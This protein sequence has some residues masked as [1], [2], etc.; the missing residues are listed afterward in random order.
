M[1]DGN[2]RISKA[3]VPVVLVMALAACGEK[4]VETA[5]TKADTPVTLAKAVEASDAGDVRATGTVAFKHEVPMSFMVSGIVQ[6]IAVDQG[7]RVQSGQRL[8]RLDLG[9]IAA[10][11]REA[12]AGV[13]K[14]ERDVA[15]L[16]PLQQKGFAP[17]SRLDDARSALQAA[18][19]VRDTVAFNRG[20]SEIV[21]P[22]DGIVLRRPAERGQIV[23]A[24][25]PV[26]VVGD[27]SKGHIAVAGL[28]DRD[29]V[30][31]AVGDAAEARIA[32]LPDAIRGTVTRIAA[33]ADPGT[34]VFDVEVTLD[35]AGRVLPSGIVAQLVIKGRPESVLTALAIP[36]GAVVEGFGSEATVFVVDPATRVASRRRVAVAGVGESG[37]RVVK[38]L[39]AGEEV[40]ASGA[41]Y[42]RDGDK[43]HVV[44]APAAT[45]LR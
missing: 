2:S 22:T 11:L 8:A 3:L 17:T 5:A 36:P 13:A 44:A 45:A 34:G 7:D 39:A 18:R 12:E 20:L 30:R 25:N 16:A 1:A 10:R 27:L 15:R 21:A 33:K 19:A 14:A 28:A 42:L 37:V 4:P 35:S 38:G 29:V 43:V 9:E 26:L 32:G 24:G 40:V 6:E 41:A 31:I 23:S